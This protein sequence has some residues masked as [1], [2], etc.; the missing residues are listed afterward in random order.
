MCYQVVERY[1][2]CRCLY[3]KHAIDPCS[4]HGSQSHLLQEKTVLVGYACA[5]HSYLS[6]EKQEVHDTEGI[7]DDISDPSDD[8][9]SEGSIFSQAISGYTTSS[10]IPV[11]GDDTIH[12]IVQSLI[13]DPLLDWPK[14][15]QCGS[16]NDRPPA[17]RDVRFFLRAFEADLRETADSALEIHV[18][19]IFRRRIG[20][21]SS[22]IS[23]YFDINENNIDLKIHDP[24]ST[25]DTLPPMTL[26]DL[27]P[28][29]IPP[30]ELIRSFMF[31]GLSFA[32]LKEN[33]RN[34]ARSTRNYVGEMNDILT[35][36]I[37]PCDTAALV[38]ALNRDA[39]GDFLGILEVFTFDLLQE[40]IDTRASAT[41]LKGIKSLDE[42]IEK[43]MAYVSSYWSTARPTWHYLPP[44]LLKEGGSP[45]DLQ[46]IGLERNVEYE[47]FQTFVCSSVAFS[48]LASAISQ[49]SYDGSQQVKI[50]S[51]L[52]SFPHKNKAEPASPASGCTRVWFT[53][54]S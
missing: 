20:Y 24:M 30:F 26:E 47:T 23:K 3:Y 39:A 27:D 15:L 18:C 53:C 37:W 35:K 28:T 54:V 8:S 44:V 5:S 38:K 42:D 12:E 9:E 41:D 34:Y 2:V 4:G 50:T 29:N 46:E 17:M 52:A 22:Q 43:I 14:L 16:A 11:N 48:N 1:S 31:D 25:T 45:I 40:A 13:N 19:E 33:I 10:F 6:F 49:F 36:N 7:L 51:F 32:T 21:F